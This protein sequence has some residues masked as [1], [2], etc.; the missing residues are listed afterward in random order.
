MLFSVAGY[1][2]LDRMTGFDL[3]TAK[4][5]IKELA[6]FHATSLALKLKHPDIFN[7]NIQPHFNP[8][9]LLAEE[10]KKM[11]HAWINTL[12]ENPE[13]LELVPRILPLLERRLYFKPREPFA[14]LG[15]GDLWINNIMVK[16]LNGQARNIKLL[17]FQFPEYRSPV[18]DLIFLLFCS[19]STEVLAESLDYLL[20]F[21]Y[22]HFV[23]MLCRLNCEIPSLTWE[24]FIEDIRTEARK[25]EIFHIAFMTMVIFASKDAVKN[26]SEFDEQEGIFGKLSMLQKEKVWMFVKTFAKMGWI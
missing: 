12:K 18:A 5:V 10:H 24:F 19:V 14:T 20:E 1:S 2:M 6:G 16:Q 15:H 7:I 3:Q 22:L 17:D 21:F 8:F 26:V 25:A 13:T 23:D 9:V 11:V 4:L